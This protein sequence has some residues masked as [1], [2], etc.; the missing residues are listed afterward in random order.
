MKTFTELS[1]SLKQNSGTEKPLLTTLF[2]KKTKPVEAKEEMPTLETIFGRKHNEPRTKLH[3]SIK[4]PSHVKQLS[5]HSQ[6][7]ENKIHKN[8]R[9]DI[10][11]D[12]HLALHKYSSTGFYRI[13]RSLYSREGKHLNDVKHIDSAL[14]KHKVTKQFHTFTGLKVNPS[15]GFKDEASKETT[16]FHHPSY[17]STSTNF[18]E[19]KSF[20]KRDKNHIKHVLK[21]HVPEGAHAASIKH[22]S[23]H[24]SEDEVLLHRGHHIEIHHKPT[25]QP[26][27]THIW[28]G[29]IVG[30]DRAR[31]K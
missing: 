4:E 19:A 30:S 23:K 15:H 21:L 17:I 24:Q 25:L 22:I 10:S 8:N 31:N 29:R 16:T 7:E 3:E 26:D 20:A 11:R 18:H 5:V 9:K 12:E 6:S 27:G 13:N 1:N 28:H 14:D 2:G